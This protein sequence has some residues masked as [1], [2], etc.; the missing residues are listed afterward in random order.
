MN[1]HAK[2]FLSVAVIFAMVVSGFAVVMPIAEE[3][4]PVVPQTMLP[5][6]GEPLDPGPYL[7]HQD[8]YAG[9]GA[10]VLLIN[11][12]MYY[13]AN[14]TG[15]QGGWDSYY[16][17]MGSA[18][19]DI[20]AAGY[21]VDTWYFSYYTGAY[22]PGRRV[23]GIRD[24]TNWYHNYWPVD[25]KYGPLDSYDD[26][27]AVIIIGYGYYCFGYNYNGNYETVQPVTA[28]RAMTGLEDYAANGGSIMWACYYSGYAP[29]YIQY[30]MGNSAV[31]ANMRPRL[32]NLF[33]VTTG[34]NRNRN[35]GTGYYTG[36]GQRGVAGETPNTGD[37]SIG[38]CTQDYPDYG[39]D[40]GDT[41]AYWYHSQAQ[42]PASYPTID[43]YPDQHSSYN[44]YLDYAYCY[45]IQN[46][47]NDGIVAMENSGV[48]YSQIRMNYGWRS[49]VGRSPNPGCVQSDHGGDF[50][51]VTFFNN[52]WM[53]YGTYRTTSNSY[54][55]GTRIGP[56]SREPLMASCLNFLIGGEKEPIPETL[57]IDE[58]YDEGEKGTDQFIELYNP[59]RDG[60]PIDL[61]KFYL[62]PL[63]NPTPGD[64]GDPDLAT[65][66]DDGFLDI[67]EFL[68]VTDNELDLGQ[69]KR[70]GIYNKADDSLAYEVAW[71][72]KGEA[73]DPV[74]GMSTQLPWD[75]D[76]SKY[77]FGKWTLATPT[78]NARNTIPVP[79]FETY[80]MV[81]NEINAD[82][83][84]LYNT[85][86]SAVVLDG[87]KVAGYRNVYTIPP[88]T[89]IQ[90]GGYYLIP[91]TKLFIADD[92][93]DMKLV[94][95]LGVLIDVMTWAPAGGRAPTSYAARHF[96]GVGLRDIYIPGQGSTYEN[97]KLA[98]PNTWWEFD[99]DATQGSRNYVGD[100]ILIDGMKEVYE[101]YNVTGG[102]YEK[103]ILMAKVKD[104]P[105]LGSWDIVLYRGTVGN[106][107]VSA[108]TNYLND[109]GHLYL[110][111]N[112]F[113]NLR[114]S[115]PNFF[116]M[117]HM[118]A[119]GFGAAL[120][121]NV[122]AGD[123]FIDDMEFKYNPTTAV[124]CRI[125]PQSDGMR[126]FYRKNAPLNRFAA[127][128]IENPT[129]GYRVVSSALQYKELRADKNDPDEFMD[130]LI[131][132]FLT[133]D[134]NHAPTLT[135]QEGQ[136]G[137]TTLVDDNDRI[138]KLGWLGWSNDDDDFWD[139]QVW[140]GQDVYGHDQ[141]KF[142]EFTLYLDS[143]MD[144]VDE[145]DATC[146]IVFTG[147]TS[148]Y[149]PDGLEPGRYYWTA[150]AEDKFGA[151]GGAED[152]WGEPV[153]FS[154]YYDNKRPEIQSVKPY[155][156]SGR[157][158][159]NTGIEMLGF[160][161][162]NGYH[163]T[164]GPEGE[165]KPEGILFKAYDEHLGLSFTELEKTEL[166]LKFVSETPGIEGKTWDVGQIGIFDKNGNSIDPYNAKNT[167]E[168]IMEI[169][170]EILDTD[171]TMYNGRY[172][173][174]YHLVDFVGNF[175]EGNVIFYID[176]DAP[177]AMTDMYVT[178]VA[179]PIYLSTGIQYLKAGETYL[180]NGTGPTTK[181]DGTLDHI[182]FVMIDKLFNPTEQVLETFSGADIAAGTTTKNYMMTFDAVKDYEFF[183]ATSYDRAGNWAQSGILQNIIVDAYAPTKPYGIEV[184][185]ATQEYVTVSGWARDS[186]VSGKTSGMAYALIYVNGR[187]VTH[188]LDGV[189]SWMGGMPYQA[190]DEMKVQVIANRFSADIPLKPIT[191]SD[192]DVK[193]V[194]QAQGVDNVGNAGELSDDTEVAPIRMMDPLKSMNVEIKE[195]SFGLSDGVDQLKEISVTF[196]QF[197]P[198]N[199]EH[200][201]IEMTY[202]AE[203]P[204]VDN[205]A[206]S[207]VGYWNVVTD[208]SGDF[209]ARVKIFF[210]HPSISAFDFNS[211]RL[212]TRAKMATNWS[213]IEDAI[214]VHQEANPAQ[215]IPELYYVEATVTSFS[216]FGI[217]QGK[218]DLQIS[219]T[220]IFAN[221]LV[222][223]QT[224]RISATVRNVGE[225]SGPAED[226]TVRVYWADE[227]GAEFTIGWINFE[228]PIESGKD[229]EQTGEV[230]WEA[231]IVC[232]V[233]KRIFYVWLRV[234][235]NAEIA[236]YNELN[237]EVF[238]DEGGDGTID[239]VE[240]LRVSYGGCPSFA[241]NL[242]MTIGATMVVAG[243]AVARYKPKK[244]KRW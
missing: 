157:G 23:R 141:Y 118:Q 192:G 63:D 125:N 211:L 101:L 82:Y 25:S 200:H 206:I 85:G 57:A 45:Y 185:S 21:T 87:Y 202:H 128:Y 154:F 93:G 8:G 241:M 120:S 107:Q 97:K 58:V 239:P 135:L 210:Q 11:T 228:N 119:Q 193:N 30:Y 139:Q 175:F 124:S 155:F 79:D 145:L 178:E 26:Y 180:L 220:H 24:S 224:V 56:W 209:K 66:D 34:Y 133:L 55:Y 217:V 148:F 75:N 123:L 44:R 171:G 189:Y 167:V 205:S 233:E 204:S 131:D 219:D 186:L 77:V 48:S 170:A 32:R 19:D 12:Y 40:E 187:V 168:F 156:L 5:A 158:V 142:V 60:T 143:D 100:T 80:S 108:L 33:D 232:D 146:Q 14:P 242:T 221:P 212:V 196:L 42:K 150:Q 244:G 165:G 208:V 83:V 112:N 161:E 4:V 1:N 102:D 227:E 35:L 181:A 6:K 74:T 235:P 197:P 92:G 27:K 37:A 229:N 236:E 115:Q 81:I 191:S 172:T 69:Y 137:A 91:N 2:K 234:D 177:E 231:P 54:K 106:D 194:I 226:V 223:G 67:D 13:Y 195:M 29:F 134:L 121:S 136:V 73:L 71:S 243:T 15:Y 16:V 215:G 166:G 127:A 113:V 47:R 130:A 198:G 3:V 59:L 104:F 151:V 222:G 88:G 46:P 64:F 122:L 190:G 174:T 90:P 17:A 61:S 41:I 38:I 147:N 89:T 240:V 138:S 72:H 173:V 214:F 132:W 129:T 183:Y 86:G 52:P 31:Q 164:F 111:E 20:H 110:E 144:K 213:V 207:M 84:E 114:G 238:M 18:V 203:T 39:Y 188:R 65:Y 182:E 153:L 218:P 98:Q 199:L 78:K 109:G 103:G 230:V 28:Q 140:N 176:A 105:Y 163:P 10:D 117:L 76:K 22:T 149:K 51:T 43:R 201:T 62:S 237:N 179:H 162:T 50:K 53:G 36:Y 99:V 160:Y 152:D 159:G 94:N 9:D 68:I 169:P 225:F 7:A 116:N 96:D 126:V 49:I 184:A 216:D 95:E 70:M